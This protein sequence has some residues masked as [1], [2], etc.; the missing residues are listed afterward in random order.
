[1]CLAHHMAK[2]IWHSGN[3]GHRIHGQDDPAIVCDKWSFSNMWDRAY[4]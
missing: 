3:V 4:K 1:M 2:T